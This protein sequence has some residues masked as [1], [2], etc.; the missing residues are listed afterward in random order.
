MSQ[1][2]SKMYIHIIFSTKDREP[3]IGQEIQ[4]ELYSVLGSVLNN[5][6]CPPIKIG[7]YHDHVHI[8]T[9]LSRNHAVKEVVQKV[10]SVSSS[11]V[12]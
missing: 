6:Q 10:K 7:G 3:V 4:L 1:S 12:K 2:L 8:L 11:W 5:L 9:A